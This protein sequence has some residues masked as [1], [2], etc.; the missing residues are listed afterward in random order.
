MILGLSFFEVMSNHPWAQARP[1][2]SRELPG[3]LWGTMPQVYKI[4]VL[5][6]KLLEWIKLFWT[7]NIRMRNMGGYGHNIK[8]IDDQDGL[9][10]SPWFIFLLFSIN[11]AEK[12]NAR[13]RTRLDRTHSR[14]LHYKCQDDD[15]QRHVN[16][17]WN[18]NWA[19]NDFDFSSESEVNL[20]RVLSAPRPSI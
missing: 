2:V 13:S 14:T 11:Y 9:R 3:P 16:V 12:W 19:R 5:F 10:D 6:L 17:I 8:S 18:L 4:Y 1:S 7:F 20:W 15:H